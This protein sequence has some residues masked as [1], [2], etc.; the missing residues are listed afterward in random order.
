MFTFTVTLGL[1]DDFGGEYN[2]DWIGRYVQSSEHARRFFSVF[3]IANGMGID[4]ETDKQEPV[5]VIQGSCESRELLD[6]THTYFRSVAESMR[7]RGFGW[8]ESEINSYAYTDYG[9]EVME[10][11]WEA[12]LI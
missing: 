5:L 3:T 8:F 1:E 2:G 4:T 9:Q 11:N 10:H 7:Q 12:E 6:D